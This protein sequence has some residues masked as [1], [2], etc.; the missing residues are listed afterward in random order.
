MRLL[1]LDVVY[2]VVRAFFAGDEAGA[3]SNTLSSDNAFSALA[4]FMPRMWTVEH[5]LRVF[6]IL[7]IPGAALVFLVLGRDL[8]P[9]LLLRLTP[10]VPLSQRSQFPA[11]PKVSRLGLLTLSFFLAKV[12]NVVSSPTTATNGAGND[13]N[14][15]G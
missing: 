14:P 3:G 8:R 11:L 12:S 10:N 2:L 15:G 7:P 4:L 5:Y 13:C 1:S 9:F 6:M